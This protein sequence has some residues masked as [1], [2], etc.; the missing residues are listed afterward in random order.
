MSTV[1]V[2]NPVNKGSSCGRKA[3]NSNNTSLGISLRTMVFTISACAVFVL[4]LGTTIG[5]IICSTAL[6]V[7]AQALTIPLGW[8]YFSSTG[9]IPTVALK[10]TAILGTVV[11]VALL[12]SNIDTLITDWGDL[13]TAFNVV[14][15]REGWADAMAF[16]LFLCML[17]V[18]TAV[19]APVPPER[20]D[21]GNDDE[22]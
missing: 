22:D 18:V 3:M 10:V 19:I 14:I 8:V 5:A 13:T 11:Y 15:D 9:K 20:D 2:D 12:A 16:T 1:F 4:T 21:Y 6:L 7:A 17:P